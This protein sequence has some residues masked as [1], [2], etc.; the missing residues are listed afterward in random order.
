M[1]PE[2]L[3]IVGLYVAAAA[4]AHCI[5]RR[6]SGDGHRHYV[7]VAGNH[8]MQIEGYIRAI[9]LFSRRTGTE[10]G[11]TVV[12]D[13]STDETGPIL[14]RMARKDSGID[15]VRRDRSESGRRIDERARD[16]GVEPVGSLAADSR[17]VWVELDRQEDVRRLPL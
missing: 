3:W 9:Q 8:Q 11:I 17:V 2:L 14:E 5:I 10:I 4:F 12:L 6:S 7:L 16:R 15:W 1:L 13:R